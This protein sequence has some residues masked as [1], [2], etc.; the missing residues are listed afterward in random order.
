M[1]LENVALLAGA[2]AAAFVSGAFGFGNALVAAAVWLPFLEPRATVPLIIITGLVM[3]LWALRALKSKPD[4]R[5]LTPFVA[6]GLIGAP[7]GTW[8][9][10]LA[11]PALFRRA[12]GVILCAYGVT[13]LMLRPGRLRLNPPR[14]ADAAVGAAAGFLGNFAGLAGILPTLWCGL[15][16]WAPD[17]QRAVYQPVQLAFGFIA[18]LGVVASGLVGVETLKRL[19]LCFPA[20]VAGLWCGYG[21]YARLNPLAFGRA[22]LT[23]VLISGAALLVQG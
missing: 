6:G 21:L 5:R 7:F 16:G 2:F 14:S 10:T 1:P 19:A 9:L 12:V 17:E 8:L 18:L 20:I 4:L 23:L 22:V 13:A 11:E 15:R 3:H